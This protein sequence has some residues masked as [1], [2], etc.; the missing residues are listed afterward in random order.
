[1]HLPVQPGASQCSELAVS[2][3]WTRAG[4]ACCET[5]RKSLCLILL[6]EFPELKF[7]AWAVQGF[8]KDAATYSLNCVRDVPNLPSFPC[9]SINW[10]STWKLGVRA[11]VPV[12][13]QLLMALV[14]S[15]PQTLYEYT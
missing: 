13:E 1:M 4:V 11:F 3:G 5:C 9:P 8:L 10:D 14:V 6:D 15:A 7:L 2:S 12:L